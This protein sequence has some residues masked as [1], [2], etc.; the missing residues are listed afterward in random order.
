MT[1]ATADGACPA[2]WAYKAGPRYII[3]RPMRRTWS[4][5]ILDQLIEAVVVA[6]ILL[7]IGIALLYLMG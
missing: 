6:L 5:F 1:V 7:S 2:C 4:E 3:Q